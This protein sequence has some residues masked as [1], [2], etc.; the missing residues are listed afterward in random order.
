MRYN[1]SVPTIRSE[2]LV[3]RRTLEDILMACGQEREWLEYKEA[4]NS[5]KVRALIGEAREAGITVR[6]IARMTGIS[7]QTLH[8]WMKRHMRPVLPV[9]YG[10]HDPRPVNLEEAVLRTIGEEPERDWHPNDLRRR[11]PPGWPTGSDAD[12][13]EALEQ[14]ARAHLIWDGDQGAFR[15]APPASGVA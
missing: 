6:D 5:G 8:A 10:L 4:I 9:H 13:A 15:L 11:I 14:L 1:S 12:V 2:N 3:R 7:T